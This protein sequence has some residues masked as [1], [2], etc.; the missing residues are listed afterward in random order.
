[1]QHFFHTRSPSPG[2]CILA[3]AQQ[4]RMEDGYPGV[5]CTAVTSGSSL[6]STVVVLGNQYTKVVFVIWVH[7][8][9][10]N[11]HSSRPCPYSPRPEV[12]VCARYSRILPFSSQKLKV[13]SFIQREIPS[14]VHLQPAT[15]IQVDVCIRGSPLDRRGD[16]LVSGNWIRDNF[17]RKARVLGA[18][19]TLKCRLF[20]VSVIGVCK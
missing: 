18:R 20:E 17:L 9:S 8:H 4:C 3:S 19:G 10:Y 14:I 7:K 16:R 2:F 11:I 13:V 6:T 12:D 5:K 15:I 1:M